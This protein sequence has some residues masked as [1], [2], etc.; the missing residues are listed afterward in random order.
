MRDRSSSPSVMVDGRQSSDRAS[1]ER[2]GPDTKSS[3]PPM[4]EYCTPAIVSATTW[5]WMSTLSAALM[6]TIVRLRP[7]ASGELTR[8]TGRNATSVLSSSQSYS[9]RVP[10]AKVATETPSYRPLR[11]VTLPASWRCMSPVVNISE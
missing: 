5:P 6:V 2:A 10:A 3:W 11:L 1:S 8:S 4:P 7:I 9:S